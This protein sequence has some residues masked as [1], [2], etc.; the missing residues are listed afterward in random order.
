MQRGLG[1][2]RGQT[3]QA[4]LICVHSTV[5]FLWREKTTPDTCSS[6]HM[7]PHPP[8]LLSVPLLLPGTRVLLSFGYELMA[9]SG[10]IARCRAANSAGLR[11]A[12]SVD[13]T[14]W[15]S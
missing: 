8:D 7:R 10:Q 14:R 13:C 9:A 4:G 12:L 5:T 11:W 15:F 2:L 3:T 1:F 6:D